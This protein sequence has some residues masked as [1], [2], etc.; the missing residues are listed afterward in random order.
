MV[1][2]A[3][4]SL[5]AAEANLRQA[6]SRLV[7]ARSAPQRIKQSRSQ[8]DVSRA[9]IDKAMADVAQARLNLSYTKIYAP[10]DGF[11][12]KKGVEPGQFVQAGQSLLAI[13]PRAV[14][15]TANF[16]ETQ[17]TQMQPG[18]PVEITV[19]AYPE[20]TFHGVV[21]S[22]QRGTGARFSLLPPEN[23]TGNYVK[24]VQRIPVKIVFDQPE[25]T[26]KALLAPGMSVVAEVTVSAKGKPARTSK[27]PRNIQV[28]P[29]AKAGAAAAP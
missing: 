19:D 29:P 3:E 10:C 4:A 28:P 5:K 16:K 8:A 9:D 12:T 21:D 7:A 24:V 1:R 17:L 6:E 2:E 25:E 27:D 11:V 15:T 22:I 13:V 18:Q 14:W 26:A 23:A 20:L